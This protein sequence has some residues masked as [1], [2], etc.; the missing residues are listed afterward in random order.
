MM[1]LRHDLAVALG[2][3][4]VPGLVAEW[5]HE[6][7]RL[8]VVIPS[9][10]DLQVEL[11][12]PEKAESPFEMLFVVPDGAESE[13]AVAVADFVERLLSEELVLAMDGRRVRGGRRWLRPEQLATE[14]HLTFVLSWK[15]S[16]DERF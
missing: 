1:R 9:G 4:C 11:H 8:A 2:P 10:G 15:G 14:H 13:V 12:V 6:A 16:Y 3:P 5:H 7:R